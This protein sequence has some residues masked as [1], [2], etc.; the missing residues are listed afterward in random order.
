MAVTAKVL[1]MAFKKGL[2]R[3]QVARKYKVPMWYVEHA[4]IQY[5]TNEERQSSKK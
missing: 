1:A 2:S 4:L 3:R 5:L